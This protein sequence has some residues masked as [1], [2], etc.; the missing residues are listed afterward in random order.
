MDTIKGIPFL[1]F[2]MHISANEPSKFIK[3]LSNLKII[4]ETTDVWN[5][6]GKMS[7]SILW[8]F[9]VIISESYV[10]CSTV[11]CLVEGEQIFLKINSDV[12]CEPL[13]YEN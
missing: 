11:S 5:A 8:S 7:K 4:E 3:I 2:T 12:A 13:L 10:C 9:C 6:V 1:V